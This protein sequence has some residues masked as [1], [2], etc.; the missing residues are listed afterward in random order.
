MGSFL[1]VGY[2]QIIAI[3]RYL[4]LLSPFK[5]KEREGDTKYYEVVI[6]IAIGVALVV[7][8]SMTLQIEEHSGRCVGYHMNH[9]FMLY[10]NSAIVLFYVIIPV[11]LLTV[12]S[13]KMVRYVNEQD[14]DSLSSH[15]ITVQ[16][17]KKRNYR[18]T[19][20]TLCVL[21]FFIISTSPTRIITVYMEMIESES[22]NVDKY[23]IL[24]LVSYFTYPLQN[25]LNPVLYSMSA[26]NW[27]KEA[28]MWF[29]KSTL[30]VTNS[31][32]RN[33]EQKEMNELM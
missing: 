15:A 21:F 20:I 3:H 9:T 11:C 32:Y 16:R 8:Y 4:F 25:T 19:Y 18:V 31:L 24:S 13:L 7:P 27:R 10:Y 23:L 1:T 14:V 22:G 5:T 30:K 12:L 2:I 33:N 17:V 29:R 6:N 26:K 28:T